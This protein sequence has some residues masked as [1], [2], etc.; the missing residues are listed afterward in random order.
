[1]LPVHDI[2]GVGLLYFAA[3]PM[4]ADLCAARHVGRA[5]LSNHS[6]TTRDICYFANAMPDETLVFRLHDWNQTPEQV[7]YRATLSRKSDDKTMALIACTKAFVDL[8]PLK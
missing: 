1:M 5:L 2:N 3:Y 7:H 6:T 8:P 4:I